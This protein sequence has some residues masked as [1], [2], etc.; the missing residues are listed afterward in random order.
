MAEMAHRDRNLSASASAE[1]QLRIVLEFLESVMRTDFDS[2]YNYKGAFLCNEIS[3]LPAKKCFFN[4][5]FRL[6]KLL[7]I[8]HFK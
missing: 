7:Y 2:T 1:T 4:K 8:Y 5:D 3:P 6:Q